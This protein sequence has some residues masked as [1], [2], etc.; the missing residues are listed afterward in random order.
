M[1]SH[2]RELSDRAQAAEGN[3]CDVKAEQDGQSVAR[4][5]E[6]EGCAGDDEVGRRILGLGDKSISEC[7]WR[8]S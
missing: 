2:A 5:S 3:V 4:L 8:P 6:E 7:S 1:K